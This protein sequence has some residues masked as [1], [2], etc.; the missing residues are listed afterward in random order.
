MTPLITPVE[1]GQGLLQPQEASVP[2]QQSSEVSPTLERAA[3]AICNCD[4]QDGGGPW[5]WHSSESQEGYRDRARAALQT[6]TEPDEAVA[7]RDIVC[8]RQRQIAVEGWTQDHDD[9][10]E[11]FQMAQAAATY[12]LAAAW[13][14][15]TERAVMDYSGD[16]ESGGDHKSTPYDLFK[17]WP[18]SEV[19]WK[20][21]NRRQDLV[22]AGALIVAEIERLDR[23]AK[24]EATGAS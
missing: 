5:D 16:G 23:A 14:D 22:R 24:A 8:E 18:W 9:A 2:T 10:H 17:H 1:G 3:R 20:P 13:P 21:R 6:I 15:K 7:V 12:A 4:E 11:G 19:W